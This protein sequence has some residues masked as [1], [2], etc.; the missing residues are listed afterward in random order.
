M[1]IVNGG[2]AVSLRSL[3]PEMT[4]ASSHPVQGMSSIGHLLH[5]QNSSNLAMNTILL[6]RGNY[7]HWNRVPSSVLLVSPAAVPL[8]I[9]LVACVLLAE[10]APTVPGIPSF[11]GRASF[12]IIKTYQCDHRRWVSQIRV[13]V[14][15]LVTDHTRLIRCLALSRDLDLLCHQLFTYC[16]IVVLTY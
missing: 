10:V 4:L 16:R 11:P 8:A 7:K 12:S 14:A 2:W 6:I 3:L 9:A 1:T 15:L 5:F 13:V